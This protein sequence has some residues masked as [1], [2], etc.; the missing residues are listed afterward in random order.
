MVTKMVSEW[1]VLGTVIIFLLSFVAMAA[2]P[3][4]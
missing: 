2:M 3:E 4:E 1:Q